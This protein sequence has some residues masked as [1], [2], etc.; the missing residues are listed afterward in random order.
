MQNAAVTWASLGLHHLI[1]HNRP[2]LFVL[3]LEL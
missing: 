1:Y 2:A 3:S